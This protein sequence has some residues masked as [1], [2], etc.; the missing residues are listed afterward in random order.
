L[1]HCATCPIN[2]SST[3][4]SRGCR[5]DAIA[6]PPGCTRPAALFNC[7]RDCA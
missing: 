6:R 2:S 7:A 1:I 3:H 5:R 4:W